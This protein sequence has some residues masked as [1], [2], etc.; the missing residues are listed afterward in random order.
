MKHRLNTER[1]Q[2]AYP[3]LIRVHPWLSAWPI[4]RIRFFGKKCAQSLLA[5]LAEAGCG[6]GFGGFLNGHGLTRESL[7]KGFGQGEGIGAAVRNRPSP[8]HCQF[9][10]LIGR[11][12]FVDQASTACFLGINQ[13]PP[14]KNMPNAALP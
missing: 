4:P 1:T 6:A 13:V 12:Y 11:D 14:P 7:Q 2:S 9:H 8:S 10:Q 3:C 5:F